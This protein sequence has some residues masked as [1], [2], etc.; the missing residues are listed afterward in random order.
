MG[1]RFVAAEPIGSIDIPYPAQFLRLGY[2][3][4]YEAD[5]LISSLGEVKEVKVIKSVHP[6]FNR[7]ITKQVRQL[8]FRPALLDGAPTAEWF[9]YTAR[10]WQE[11]T[12]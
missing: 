5:L 4:T 12:R 6:D 3:G 2:E 8:R 7:V 11:R 10:Y 1:E 9:R